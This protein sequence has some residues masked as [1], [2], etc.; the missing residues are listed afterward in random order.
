ML[1]HGGLRR[2]GFVPNERGFWRC[3]SA[4]YKLKA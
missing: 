4:E 2:A 1:T 3:A